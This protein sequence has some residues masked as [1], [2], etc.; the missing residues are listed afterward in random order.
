[1]S[2]IYFTFRRDAAESELAGLSPIAQRLF[3]RMLVWN[4]ALAPHPGGNRQHRSAAMTFFAYLLR[5][6]VASPAAVVGGLRELL[7]HD[8][9]SIAPESQADLEEALIEAAT[10][11]MV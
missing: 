7:K 11:A 3:S 5:D 2:Q 6:P 9:V 4:P 8:L 1:M 10:G